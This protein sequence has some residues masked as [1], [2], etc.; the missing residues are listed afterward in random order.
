M[1]AQQ[2]YGR[3]LLINLV[4]ELALSEPERI[5]YSIAASQDIAQGFRHVTARNFANAVNRTAWWLKSEL[6]QGISFP[7]I[8]FIGPCRSM[9]IL[10]SIAGYMQLTTELQTVTSATSFSFWAA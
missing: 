9:S 3:R 8:G 6:G 1:S 7:S 2:V 5:V 10:C 4:D